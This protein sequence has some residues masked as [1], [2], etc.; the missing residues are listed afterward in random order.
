MD[1]GELLDSAEPRRKVRPATILPPD[2]RRHLGRLHDKL[3]DHVRRKRQKPADKK[4]RRSQNRPTLTTQT[5]IQ[6][7]LFSEVGNQPKR[8]NR[9]KGG[10][11]ST[12]VTTPHN[13]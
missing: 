10:Q 13:Q 6:T 4:E 3:I 8:E 2:P 11:T 12:D 7:C 9:A 5:A 1:I